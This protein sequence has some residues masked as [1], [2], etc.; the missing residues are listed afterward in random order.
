MQR[1]LVVDNYPEVCAS[2]QAAL[3]QFG[4]YQV[5]TVPD[6]GIALAR[7]AQE[8]PDLAIVDAVLPGVSGLELAG[9]MLARDVPVVLMTGEKQMMNRL[10]R[11]GLAYLPKPFGLQQ[12]IEKVTRIPADIEELRRLIRD[13][14]AK[15]LSVSMSLEREYGRFDAEM[16]RFRE[17]SEAA[18][19]LRQRQR[20]GESE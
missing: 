11:A 17:L 7:M 12:L 3:E 10:K 15:L 16:R 5:T 13:D 14:L 8:R 1:V 2:L 4:K 18:R 9:T 20:D 6:G 19:R